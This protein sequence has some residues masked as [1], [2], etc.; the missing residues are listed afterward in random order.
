[1]SS[2]RSSGSIRAESAVEPTR[3]E[4]ITVTWRR[5]AVSWVFGSVTA[6][7][8]EEGASGAAVRA[9]IAFGF[10][11]WP[12]DATPMSLRSSFVSR[13][14]SSP[15]MS[16]ARKISAYW[17]RPIPRSQPSMSKFSP[18]LG[19]CQR[20]FSKKVESLAPTVIPTGFLN[21][22]GFAMWTPTTRQKY[23]RTVSGMEGFEFFRFA[24][25]ALV[26]NDAVPGRSRLY[27]QFQKEQGGVLDATPAPPEGLA[28]AFEGS[29][30]IGTPG[31]F[32]AHIKHFQDAGVDQIILLQQAGRNRHEHICESLDLLARDVLPEFAERAAERDQRKADEL[33]PHVEK[34]LARKKSMAP[35]ADADIPVVKASVARPIVNT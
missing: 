5:S 10:L 7:G 29:P 4:N 17:T 35:L 31:D 6:T 9:A 26:T 34:A 2:R 3:S 20:Q 33:A 19:S 21:Q 25:S 13:P 15:S 28:S 32:C 27:E 23:S 14:S 24:I 16:L 8:I 11:R 22:L 30:G 1:M 18:H 12:S